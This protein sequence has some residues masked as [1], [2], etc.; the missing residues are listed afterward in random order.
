MTGLTTSTINPSASNA[1]HNI[2]FLNLY[3]FKLYTKKMDTIFYFG[4]HAAWNQDV[5][6][7]E[8]TE[9]ATQLC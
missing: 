7:A 3:I 8:K 5:S 4:W 9:A 1:Y 6:T 2:Y